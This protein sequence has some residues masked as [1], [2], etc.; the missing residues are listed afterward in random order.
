MNLSKLSITIFIFLLAVILN[1]CQQEAIES[2]EKLTINEQYKSISFPLESSQKLIPIYST[3]DN[4]SI[5]STEGWCHPVNQGDNELKISVDKN[6]ATAQR[7]AII[8]I[9]T[10]TLSETINIVQFGSDPV[11]A[12]QN[13]DLRVDYKAQSITVNI[14]SNIQFDYDITESWIKKSPVLKNAQVD[15]VDYVFEFNVDQLEQ[16]GIPRVGKIYFKETNGTV[17]DSVTVFQALTISDT[18]TPIG[19]ESF[20]KDKKIPVLSAVLSPSDKYQP[21]Q[22]I[23]KSYDNDLSTLYHSPWGGMPDKP[24]LSFEYNLDPAEAAIANYVVLHPRSSGPNG[25]IKKA[26]VWVTTADNPTYT[27]VGETDVP[28]SN[29]PIKI[30]FPTPVI[31]PRKVK[32][33]VSDAYSGDAGKYYVS[34]A[35]FECYENRSLN[36]I[37]DDLHHFTDITCS[38]LRAGFT[39]SNLNDIKNPFIQNIAAYL[40]AGKY[41]MEFRVQQYEPYRPVGDLSAELKISG[42]NQFENPTG[43]YFEKG[44]EVVIFVGSSEAENLSLR[45]TDFGPGGDD[46]SYPL[47]NGLNILT[48][49]GNGNGY[50]NY[51]TPEYQ[52]A[53]GIKIHIASGKV[54]G[55]F[56]S[57]RHNEADGIALLDNAISPILDIVGE[58]VQLAYSVA[59][60]KNNCYGQLKELITLY[61]DIMTSQHMIM[62]LNKYNKEPKNH[63]FGRV[64]WQGYMHADGYGAAF[65]DN[66]MNTVAN[67]SALRQNIWGVAHE[68]GHVN[69]TRPGLKWVGTSEC[70]NNIFS[71]WNQYCYTP[72]SLRLEHENISGTIGGRFNA[73]FT[74]GII[75]G[76]EW[77]LQAGP[78]VTYGIKANGRWGGDHFVKLVPLWQLQLYYHV[79]GEGN[80][81][82]QPY[83]WADIFEKV[84]NTDESSFS[85][86]KLQ[87]NFVKNVCDAVQQDL[88]D[89]FLKIGMLKEVDKYFDDYAPAQKTITQSMIDETINYVSRYP[90]PQSNV[91]HYI[92][93]NCIDA[94]KHKRKVAGQYN[95]GINGSTS[96][97][98]SHNVWQNVVVFET[99]SG[100]ELSFITMVGTG[101]ST[102]STTNVPYPGGSTRIE[103]V[104][105]D[106]SR[107]LVTGSR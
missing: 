102:N 88:S 26:S 96:K 46:N 77:G 82:H 40:L 52:T 42:Y 87:M 97:V 38:E 75:N 107:T 23:D 8:T 34:L 68:F 31:N 10:N 43:I 22:N 85:D 35:E 84:R 81:W 69:Q 57:G 17:K 93:G 49:K 13:K 104:S 6:P 103:A 74:N 29:T 50:I 18:Y 106:G 89:F 41:N 33:D 32:V 51:F 3:K 20:E 90:K 15:L 76:Q 70:T 95:N 98:I 63:I 78:D 80:T 101:S 21:G 62:G 53:P 44:E 100:N 27:L 39:T 64:I 36:A 86:G 24:V 4:W 56:D 61:D 45:I 7:S 58:K 14:Q 92:N 71:A 28:R 66:T 16:S 73:F 1:A 19:T 105:Y 2:P 55:Y 5:S 99:Y 79:A 30:N 11:I 12:I 54:N 37:S 83:F 47:S 48:I 67:P 72:G 94:F 9:K 91:I 65:H 25:I 59:S 60:L